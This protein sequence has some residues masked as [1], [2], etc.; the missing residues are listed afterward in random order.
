V[1][2]PHPPV[3]PGSRDLTNP[4]F[5]A[6]SLD[7]PFDHPASPAHA[8]AYPP[9]LR[10]PPI[11]QP[12]TTNPLQPNPDQLPPG[13]HLPWP[14]QRLTRPH[15]LVRYLHRGDLQP[16]APEPTNTLTQLP[17]ANPQPRVTCI[18]RCVARA[19]LYK[20]IL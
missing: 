16:L 13:H 10:S 18:P 19:K 6:Q 2:R 20:L 15:V 5:A 8:L 9:H 1:S 3:A 4:Y 11:I 7:Q 12:P 17:A 14:T